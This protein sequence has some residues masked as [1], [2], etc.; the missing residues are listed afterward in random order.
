MSYLYSYFLS[1]FFDVVFLRTNDTVPAPQV[2]LPVSMV[3]GKASW[4]LSNSPNKTT[5]PGLDTIL[6][7]NYGPDF[8][9]YWIVREKSPSGS[10][11]STMAF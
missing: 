8:M 10:S 5:C 2:M 7:R 9:L 3:P 1:Y 11:L 6:E 4:D